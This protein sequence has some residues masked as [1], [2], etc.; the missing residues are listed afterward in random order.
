[1]EFFSPWGKEPKAILHLEKQTEEPRLQGRVREIRFQGWPARM[2]TGVRPAEW[3]EHPGQLTTEIAF[4][5]EGSWWILRYFLFQEQGSV[6]DI[7]WTYF[8]TFRVEVETS[9]GSRTDRP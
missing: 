6:S 2:G 4:Q 5:H 3:L 8:E 7:M 1:M 9:E